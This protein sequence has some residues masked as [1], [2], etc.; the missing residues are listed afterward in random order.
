MILTRQIFYILENCYT[1]NI[2][3]NLC[4]IFEPM[5]LQIWSTNYRA[6]IIL[7]PN[8]NKILDTGHQICKF[9]NSKAV[10]NQQ[11]LKIEHECFDEFVSWYNPCSMVHIIVCQNEE[12]F[13]LFHQLTQDI[14]LSKSQKITFWVNWWKTESFWQTI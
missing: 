14:Y 10:L 5:N 11:K 6:C 3:V 9:K 4:Y 7:Y 13:I 2:K 1:R 8:I 12:G